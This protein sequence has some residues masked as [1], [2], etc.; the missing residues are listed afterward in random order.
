MPFL[1][2]HL[3]ALQVGAEYAALVNCLLPI[4][5]FFGPSIAG[6]AADKIGNLRMVL[7]LFLVSAA[8]THL[9][10]L[11]VPGVDC[12]EEAIEGWEAVKVLVDGEGITRYDIGGEVDCRFEEGKMDIGLQC[13]PLEGM[14]RFRLSPNSPELA[15]N[16]SEL[17]PYNFIMSGRVPDFYIDVGINCKFFSQINKLS[18]N[19]HS[20]NLTHPHRQLLPNH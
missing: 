11:A 2:L 15:S 5:A 10:L 18:N 17:L 16:D 12:E 14:D 9:C 3:K 1:T 4:F 7:A 13:E 8:A 19:S 6:F 20:I